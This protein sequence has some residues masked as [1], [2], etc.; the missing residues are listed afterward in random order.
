MSLAAAGPQPERLRRVESLL[1]LELGCQGGLW[2]LERPTASVVGSRQPRSVSA[3]TRWLRGTLAA[4][5]HARLDGAVLVASL[6]PLPYELAAWD[7]V[8]AGA[9]LILV[10]ERPVPPEGTPEHDAW[11][12]DHGP[13][14]ERPETLVLCL[15][16]KLPGARGAGARAQLRDRVVD[17]LADA[18]L[19]VEVRGGG[20][21]LALLEERLRRG[22]SVLSGPAHDR[23]CAG[24]RVLLEQGAEP[25]DLGVPARVEAAGAPPV[26]VP[27][28]EPLDAA[29]A[30]D[31]LFHYTRA[32]PGPWPGQ[33]RV[34]YLEELAGGAAASAHTGLD[35]L[36][37]IL[38]ERR[39]RA[40]GRLIRA[41]QPVCCFTD[42]APD[43]IHRLVR[44]SRGQLCW[45]FEPYAIGL[46]Q[47]YALAKGLRPVLHLPP[48]AY[49]SLA[50]DERFLYQR[51]EPPAVDWTAEGEWRRC[52]DLDLADA[53][54]GDVIVLVPD[55]RA[56]AQVARACPFRVLTLPTPW[57]RAGNEK[58][59]ARYRTGASTSIS[60]PAR[61]RS[62]NAIIEAPT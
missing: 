58:A 20:V 30:A 33:R 27:D 21:W 7:A 31:Y 49:A 23:G 8:R 38:A 10:L 54:T 13:L 32:Q 41:S 17:A 40:G 22:A 19:A 11:R 36:L 52:G 56:A 9:H 26:L 60:P 53:R 14:V 12:R 5:R 37:R 34:D 61:Q 44:Y 1:G 25:V 46:R 51:H 55:A 48:A 2:L 43:E 6:G 62:R 29:E 45:S 3:D 15:P 28:A 47:E 4:R 35:A 57:A 42:R 24:N 50:P 59:P 39:I 18:V 16:E